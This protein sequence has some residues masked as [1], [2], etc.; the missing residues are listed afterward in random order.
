MIKLRL[1]DFSPFIDHQKWDYLINKLYPVISKTIIAAIPN[2]YSSKI[3]IDSEL[4]YENYINKLKYLQKKGFEIAQ[5]GYSHDYPFEDKSKVT[6]GFKRNTTEFCNV[7]ISEQE[8]R[9]KIGKEFF[10]KLNINIDGFVAPGHS[11]DKNTLE[12]CEKYKF[13]WFGDSLKY[14]DNRNYNFR[15]LNLIC[16]KYGLDKFILRRTARDLKR[17]INYQIVIHP[18]TI[19]NKELKRLEYLI[20]LIQ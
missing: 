8:K 14:N 3:K 10:N 6:L 5:H 18:N 2:H 20:Y 9:I 11:F 13:K 19:S 1:D 7:S 12:L 16:S 4:I 17:K 15:K